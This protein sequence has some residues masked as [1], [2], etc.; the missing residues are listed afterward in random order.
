MSNVFVTNILIE[1]WGE[2]FWWNYHIY[3]KIRMYSRCLRLTKKFRNWQYIYLPLIIVVHV[4]YILHN[5]LQSVLLHAQPRWLSEVICNYT[6][7]CEDEGH[8]SDR[9]DMSGAVEMAD[10]FL[11]TSMDNFLLGPITDDFLLVL[12]LAESGWRVVILLLL[13][14]LDSLM[15]WTLTSNNTS[16]VAAV[17][18][19]ELVYDVL[20]Q[21]C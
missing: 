20:V 2:V 8:L 10:S 14:R 9:A 13:L 1:V 16:L 21:W 17:V 7:L 15:N 3:W 11:V 4:K 19:S 18:V 6:K 5:C 12:V